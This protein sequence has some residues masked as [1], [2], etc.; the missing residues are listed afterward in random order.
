[1]RTVELYDTATGA[2]ERSEAVEEAIFAKTLQRY[3]LAA[4]LRN[5]EEGTAKWA[6]R[7]KPT[8]EER[9]V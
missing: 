3:R 4:E 8:D 5:R 6:A 7:E 2:I 9:D 1:M